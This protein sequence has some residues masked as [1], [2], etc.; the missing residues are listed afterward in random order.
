MKNIGS[1]SSKNKGTGDE[2]TTKTSNDDLYFVS[3]EEK[4]R[5]EELDNISDFIKR[6]ADIAD[7]VSGNK[8]PSKPKQQ[9]RP[10]NIMQQGKPQ[11]F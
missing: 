2:L 1:K 8:V 4:Q 7:A 10:Q 11:T 3:E 9:K 6:S 5:L